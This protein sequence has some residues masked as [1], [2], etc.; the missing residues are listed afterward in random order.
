MVP[1]ITTVMVQGVPAHVSLAGGGIVYGT[2]ALL[3][4]LMV[5][6][7]GAVIVGGLDQEW[8]QRECLV[9]NRS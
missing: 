8:R 3:V 2:P 6:G 9:F 1:F 4:A 7:A 5:C